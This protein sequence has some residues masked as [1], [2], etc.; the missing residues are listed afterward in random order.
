MLRSGENLEQIFLTFFSTKKE[1]RGWSMYLA[2]DHAEAV[3][4]YISEVSPWKETVFT[5]TFGC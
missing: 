1:D 3:E 4:G 5:M 2:A